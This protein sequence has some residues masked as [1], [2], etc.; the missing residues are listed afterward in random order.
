M[1]P[2]RPFRGPCPGERRRPRLMSDLEDPPDAML[3][4]STLEACNEEFILH[5]YD[6]TLTNEEEEGLLVAAAHGF[7]PYASPNQPLEED[8]NQEEGDHD[9]EEDDDDEKWDGWMTLTTY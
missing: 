7:D 5:E 2:C 4:L 9:Q 8:Y 6:P 1:C 3:C